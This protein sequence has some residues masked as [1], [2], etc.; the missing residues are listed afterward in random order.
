MNISSE[1]AISATV[2]AL[3]NILQEASTLALSADDALKAGNRNLAMGTLLSL[4]EM[5]P[6]AQALLQAS[7]VLHRRNP[8]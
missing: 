1:P 3:G 6:T 8:S 4:E 2:A 7:L 5:L